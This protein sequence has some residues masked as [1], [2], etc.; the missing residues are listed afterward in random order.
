VEELRR[1]HAGLARWTVQLAGGEPEVVTG[2]D[3]D[4]LLDA[5]RARGSVVRFA[6]VQATL[7]ELFREAVEA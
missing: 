3:P 6:P 1:G 2:D 4:A 5:A 7:S